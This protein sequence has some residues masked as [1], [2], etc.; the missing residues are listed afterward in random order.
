MADSLVRVEK[1][2][3]VIE[4]KTECANHT[5]RQAIEAVRFGDLDGPGNIPVSE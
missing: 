2:E 3:C 5:F 1:A 4:G